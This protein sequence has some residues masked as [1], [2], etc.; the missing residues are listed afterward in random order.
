MTNF[1]RLAA[2]LLVSAMLLAPAPLQACPLCAEAV[3]AGS[4]SED[5]ASNFPTAM[6]QSI[7]LMIAVPYSALG[8]LGFM[9]YR[10]V[11]Q[12]EAYRAA[13]QPRKIGTS[14]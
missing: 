7:Y 2:L 12:N 14:V 4:D 1:I 3:A 10:G 8:I 11:Q 13:L 6:N 9:I 5:D